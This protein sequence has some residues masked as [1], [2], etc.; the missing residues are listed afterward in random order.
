[1]VKGKDSAASLPRLEARVWPFWLCDPGQVTTSV[2]FA[3]K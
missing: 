2:S 3:V 1:M